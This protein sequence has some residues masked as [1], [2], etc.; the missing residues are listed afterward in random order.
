MPGLDIEIHEINFALHDPF[1]TKNALLSP[2]LLHEM[3]SVKEMNATASSLK[4]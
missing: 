2:N 1:E 4:K 3:H